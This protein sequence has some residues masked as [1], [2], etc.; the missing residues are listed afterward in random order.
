MMPSADGGRGVPVSADKILE[1]IFSGGTA[2]A[3]LILVFLGALITSFESRINPAEATVKKYKKRACIAL[4]G[5]F[6]SLL[7]A[8]LAM[9]TYWCPS[10]ALFFSSLTVLGLAFALTSVLAAMA[11]VDLG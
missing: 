3:G 2:L 10:A 4:S 11:V 7:S 1:L 8:V 9:G 5:F 6:A